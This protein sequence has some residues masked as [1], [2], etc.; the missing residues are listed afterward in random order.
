MSGTHRA[1]SISRPRL[2]LSAGIL[3]ASGV[4]KYHRGELTIVDRPGLEAASCECYH[5]IRA[6]LDD[7]LDRA[8]LRGHATP[9]GRHTKSGQDQP[10]TPPA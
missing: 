9:V 1:T 10:P 5:V 6:E 3:Q 2:T 7:A 8:H 4:I